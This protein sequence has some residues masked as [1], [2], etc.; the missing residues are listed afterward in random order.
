MSFSL[1]KKNT[2]SESENKKK[3]LLTVK[4]YFVNKS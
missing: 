4:K 3:I 1:N 2:N